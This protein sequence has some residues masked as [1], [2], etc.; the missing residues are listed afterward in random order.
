MDLGILSLTSVTTLI[1][2]L[3]LLFGRLD[4]R[5]ARARPDLASLDVRDA[6]QQLNMIVMAWY[7]DANQTRTAIRQWLESNDEAEFRQRIVRVRSATRSNLLSART[8]QS[9]IESVPRSGGPSSID[10]SSPWR[11]L[12]QLL[13]VYAP[14]LADLLHRVFTGRHAALEELMDLVHTES[15]QGNITEIMADLESTREGL[16][17]AADMITEYLRVNFPLS[18]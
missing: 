4:A 12:I 7:R 5:R 14:E 10:T 3:N 6:L 2:A 8:A 16:R 11:S 15:G 18:D 13:M 9:I 1:S 17:E